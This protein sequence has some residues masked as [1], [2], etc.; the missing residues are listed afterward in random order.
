MPVSEG[1]QYTFALGSADKS[2]K[3]FEVLEKDSATFS[4]F[5]HQ[6]HLK[7]SLPKIFCSVFHFPP[8]HQSEQ[9]KAQF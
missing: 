2:F 8:S 9:H 4:Y 6:W 1:S 3:D 5:F 7:L